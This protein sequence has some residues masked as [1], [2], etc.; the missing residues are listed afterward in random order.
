MKK[1]HLHFL[2]GLLCQLFILSS[3]SLAFLPKS[4]AQED[5]CA[6]YKLT[7]NNGQINLSNLN[8]PIEIIDIYDA[9]WQLVFSCRGTDCGQEVSLPN[10]SAGIFHVSMQFYSEYWEYVCREQIDVTVTNDD[11]DNGGDGTTFSCNEIT[12]NVTGNSVD[13]SGQSGSSYFF[14]I[15]DLNNN[16]QEAFSCSYNCGDSQ[17]ATDLADGNYIVRVYNS[18]WSI[19][20][21]QPID[22]TSDN[23]GGT[24]DDCPEIS[25]IPTEENM[26]YEV[27]TIDNV[28]KRV[29]V[30]QRDAAGNIIQTNT[31]QLAVSSTFFQDLSSDVKVFED[32]LI[33]GISGMFDGGIFK[34]LVLKIDLNGIL[35]W[36]KLNDF[37]EGANEFITIESQGQNGGYYL[38]FRGQ[39][40]HVLV[41][42]DNAGNQLW[43]QTITAL[44]FDKY[45]IEFVGE[46][47]DGSAFYVN[48]YEDNFLF[49]V[50]KRNTN[51]GALIWEQPL[52]L[53]GEQFV[54]RPFTLITPDD[55]VIARY[56][57]RF[58]TTD[59]ELIDG[60]NYRKLDTNGATD[61]IQ[62]L[63]Q[64]IFSFDNAPNLLE[65][66]NDFYLNA[67]GTSGDNELY[68]INADGTL[69]ACG[70]SNPTPPTGSCGE[71]TITTTGN[72]I[73]MQGQ[74]G[75][76]YF[77]KVHDLNNNW[78][79]AFSCSYNCGDSQTANNLANG[80]YMVRVY[81][82]SWD[83][84][85]EQEVNLGA[86]SRNR[87]PILKAF[88]VYPNPAQEELFIDL[89]AFNE[90]E[91]QIL[92][93]NLFGQ[94]VYQQSIESVSNNT[95]LISLE[96]FINGVYVVNLRV[97]SKRIRSEKLLV[98]RLY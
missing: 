38:Q 60:F 83:L 58:R 71:I 7:S 69:S 5:Y 57:W 50:E 26:G 22:L 8:A 73:S 80:N 10:L 94:I 41:G 81:D 67:I 13:M 78:Q 34:Y 97:G 54:P 70:A 4:Y 19:I 16:W 28:N 35:I 66:E 87:E 95:L 18:S 9:N 88:T 24:G 61:W 47:S 43:Q 74:S 31:Y 12:I 82:S 25:E 37:E 86:V 6:T 23:D 52:N 68:A 63:P 90:A 15:H 44:V 84:I 48:V 32:H 76:A 42:T 91:V 45:F 14:K 30:D 17:T 75:N 51:N 2:K 36:Q 59:F 92:I 85:C 62:D 40:R 27:S 20:C 72:S 49:T 55:G 56:T 3:L 46:V 93:T 29:T 33:V 65:I 96:N 11:D 98:Q 21:E 77:F 39:G 79:E 89:K 1:T 53:P 64:D